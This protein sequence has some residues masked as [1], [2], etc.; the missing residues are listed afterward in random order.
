MHNTKQLSSMEQFEWC[1]IG[2][3][4]PSPTAN[5]AP[6]SIIAKEIKSKGRS[7]SKKEPRTMKIRIKKLLNI[8]ERHQPLKEEHCDR[9]E[10]TDD[11]TNW[12][13]KASSLA[14][15]EEEERHE[16][17]R[18]GEDSAQQRADPETS[19]VNFKNCVVEMIGNPQQ[20][21]VFFLTSAQKEEL[22]NKI[23][24][25]FFEIRR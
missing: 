17:D 10:N 2:G 25:D 18:L 13:S 21:K 11:C 16:L 4:K 9:S 6:F 12:T 8:R 22:M 5:T 7:I 3:I 23:N 15:P 20:H 14:T 24:L 1:T 19:H